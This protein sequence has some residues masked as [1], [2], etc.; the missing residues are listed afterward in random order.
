MKSIMTYQSRRN[1]VRPQIDSSGSISPLTVGRIKSA[2]NSRASGLNSYVKCTIILVWQIF[3]HASME[4]RH[5]VMQ[6]S[7]VLLPGSAIIYIYHNYREISLVYEIISYNTLCTRQREKTSLHHGIA[8][9][10]AEFH[11]QCLHLF[12]LLERRITLLQTI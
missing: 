6:S 11:N 10:F 9:L 4:T 8:T 1:S 12:N 5:P 2:T 7:T 3:T